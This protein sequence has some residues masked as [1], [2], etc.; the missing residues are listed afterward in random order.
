MRLARN[1]SQLLLIDVQERLLPAIHDRE[2]VEQRCRRLIQCARRLEVPVTVSEQYPK[3]LG[4]TTAPLRDVLGNAA[5]VLPKTAFSCLGE[6]ALAARLEALRTA[7]RDLIVIA[8]IE[9]HVCVAQTALDLAAGDWEVFAAAD[10]LGSREPESRALALDR[11][12]RHGIDVVDSEMV[13]FEWLER[14]G[15]PEFKELQELLK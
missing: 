4:P 10:A 15:T 5:T 3:G 1:R 14:A 13:M 12:A 2:R 7:G 11:M 9:A 8:G 6:P